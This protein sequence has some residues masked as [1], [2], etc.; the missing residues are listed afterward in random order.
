[1]SVFL[2][3]CGDDVALLRSFLSAERVW[4]KSRY[5]LRYRSF[6][7]V[8]GGGVNFRGDGFFFV[9]WGGVALFYHKIRFEGDV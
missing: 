3:F 9:R 5:P 8:D 7:V 6:S 1:M 4:K 2:I